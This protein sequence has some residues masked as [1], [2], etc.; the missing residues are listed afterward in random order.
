VD[1]GQRQVVAELA[2]ELGIVP[3]GRVHQP[4]DCGRGRFLLQKAPNRRAELF[5]LVRERELDAAGGRECR[6]V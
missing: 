6:F 3:L 1:P 2:P 4:A 5:L